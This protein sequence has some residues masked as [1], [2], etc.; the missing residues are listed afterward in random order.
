[1][2]KSNF[3]TNT[4]IEDLIKN[5]QQSFLR[6]QPFKDKVTKTIN[7]FWDS[8]LNSIFESYG[9]YKKSIVKAI[10]KTLP[11]PETSLDGV[12]KIIDEVLKDEM[13]MYNKSLS[14]KIRKRIHRVL[15]PYEKEMST[16]LL[17]EI[18]LTAF[19]SANFIN[20][21][22]I[23]DRH[24]KTS[25]LSIDELKIDFEQRSTSYDN[26]SFYIRIYLKAD[27]SYY[28]IDL[29]N[30]TF[31]LFNRNKGK[32]KPQLYEYNINPGLKKLITNHIKLNQS[33][34]ND[35]GGRYSRDDKVKVEGL[36]SDKEDGSNPYR[37][38]VIKTFL[39]KTP[40]NHHCSCDDDDDKKEEINQERL[41][42]ASR[43]ISD[44]LFKVD[45]ERIQFNMSTQE[46][47]DAVLKKVIDKYYS[48]SENEELYEDY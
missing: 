2:R 16:A 38:S 23:I 41:E 4:S 25:G 30:M 48:D 37:E 15:L 47:L 19:V 17:V 32:E 9:D 46:E 22:D 6:S 24:G 29:F 10:E 43:Y 21:V 45:S 36:E 20:K 27:S 31:Y 34:D 44:V 40:E 11:S 7:G 13:S 39:F 35:A 5:E 33:N 8:V 42:T 14:E 28:D 12:I 18:L 26:D 1:M 3:K